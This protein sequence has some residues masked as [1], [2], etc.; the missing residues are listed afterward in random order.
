MDLTS[1]L[2]SPVRFAFG[3]GTTLQREEQLG[4]FLENSHEFLA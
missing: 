2:P 1:P 3:A 4:L